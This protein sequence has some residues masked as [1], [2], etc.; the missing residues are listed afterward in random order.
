MIVDLEKFIAGERPYWAELETL[1]EKLANDPGARLDFTQ[2]QRFHYL[3][4]R[5]SAGLAKTITIASEPETRRYLE[6]LV[7]RA[8]CEIHETRDKEGP[9]RLWRWFTVTFPST[10]RRHIRAFWLSVAITLVG[11]AFGGFAV[12]Y[13]SEAKAVIMPFSH[14]QGSPKDRVAQEEKQDKDN[15]KGAKS[16]FSAM[17]MTHNT[18]VSVMTLALGATWGFGSIVILF[19][20]GVILGAVSADYIIAGEAKFLAGWLLPH[21]SFEIPAI[22]IAGQAGLMLGGAMIG[23]GRRKS[24]RQRLR[25][26]S[27]DLTTLIFGVAI[28]LVWAGIVESFF[29]QYHEPVIP[30]V[31]KI[32]FGIVELCALAWFLSRSGAHTNERALQK[33]PR[34]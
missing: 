19:Y 14:L 23:W 21:G 18:Q 10:F 27:S 28:L 29:S 9:P 17:L 15:L 5:A 26:I 22:L 16:R 6:S 13:D 2:A 3:Y 24:M 8:Y 12:A 32:G 33:E 30:Y 1:L 11:C 20:N 34:P 31:W 7:A 25:E 4:E